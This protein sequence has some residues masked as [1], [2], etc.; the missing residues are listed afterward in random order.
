MLYYEFNI[1]VIGYIVSALCIHRERFSKHIT[2][3][4]FIKQ[5]STGAH[6]VHVLPTLF[7]FWAQ[8][9]QFYMYFPWDARRRLNRL[10]FVI[11]CKLFQRTP[12]PFVQIKR[13]RAMGHCRKHVLDSITMTR[14]RLLTLLFLARRASFT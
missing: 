5:Y 4:Q 2:D 3:G 7:H 8:L 14:T 6:S 10:E 12:R 13:C 1:L 9:Q 11:K